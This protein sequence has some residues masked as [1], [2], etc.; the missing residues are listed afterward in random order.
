MPPYANANM[1]RHHPLT[2]ILD[3]KLQERESD[4]FPPSKKTHLPP[5]KKTQ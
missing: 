4:S 2:V 1:H 3:Q 5:L